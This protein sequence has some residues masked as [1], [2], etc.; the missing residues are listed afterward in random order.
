MIISL[1]YR[2][3]SKIATAFRQ[4]ATTRLKEY[5]IKRF[6]KLTK[7]MTSTAQKSWKVTKVILIVQLKI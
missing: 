5:I 1:G 7:S 6:K 4:W 2:I 3:N